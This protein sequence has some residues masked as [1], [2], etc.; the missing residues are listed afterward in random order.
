MPKVKI[1]VDMLSQPSRAVLLFCR[2]NKIDIEVNMIHLDHGDHYQQEN[3]L[4]NPLAQVPWMD[5]DGF[6]LAES[7]SIMR[8]LAATKKGVPDHWY[9]SN[10]QRRARVNSALDWELSTLRR[11][12]TE[13]VLSK[14]LGPIYGISVPDKTEKYSREIL[15]KSLGLLED[16]WLNG[17]GRFIAGECAPTIAD[18]SLVCELKQLDLMDVEERSEIVDKYKRVQKWMAEVEQELGPHFEDVHKVHYVVAAR[19]QA[20]REEMPESERHARQSILECLTPA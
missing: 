14:V 20:G 3:L 4:M 7:H 8:Y 13:L 18:L 11:G 16:Y 2:L 12:C 5:D 9:P 15:K 1:Y 6:I 19:A 10:Q 17:P